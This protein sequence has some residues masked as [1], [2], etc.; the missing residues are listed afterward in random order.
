M[1]R[2]EGGRAKIVVSKTL[3]LPEAAE[4]ILQVHVDEGE[5]K[6]YVLFGDARYLCIPAERI[7]QSGADPRMALDLSR[8]E[9][10][11]PYRLRIGTEK[12][13]SEELPADYLRYLADPEFARMQEERAEISQRAWGK[14]LRELRRRRKLS[15]KELAERAGIDESTLARLERGERPASLDLLRRLAQALDL[16]PVELLPEEE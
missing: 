11:D 15:R 2:R 8:V 13:G 16:P 14:R 9:L 7:E 3:T 10:L 6:L 4:M 5:R 12:G 1:T